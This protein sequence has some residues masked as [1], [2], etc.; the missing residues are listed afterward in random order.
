MNRVPGTPCDPSNA[1]W[2]HWRR[3]LCYIVS[4]SAIRVHFCPT[5]WTNE[6]LEI[7]GLFGLVSTRNAA[8]EMRIFAPSPAR[9]RKMLSE[10][11]EQLRLPVESLAMLLGTPLVTVR[12]WLNGERNP[13]GA[14]KRLIWLIHCAQF[15]PSV[16]RKM[17][18]W[19]KWAASHQAALERF[20]A[21]RKGPAELAAVVAASSKE[22]E[23][24]VPKAIRVRRAQ[25][26][27]KLGEHLGGDVRHIGTAL[28][29][30]GAMQVGQSLKECEQCFSQEGLDLETKLKLLD[31]K[32][33]LLGQQ[34]SL[35]KTMMDWRRGKFGPTDA[36]PRQP[37]FAPGERVFPAT[38]PVKAGVHAADRPVDTAV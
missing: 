33:A 24:H 28:I 5:I 19:T 21:D 31:L 9:C 22:R 8:K 27:A 36:M 13:S 23:F 10:I 38:L 15:K 17:D 30:F 37:T 12:K 35:A 32:T 14:A 4:M 29:V 1:A 7:S 2:F 20:T 3:L 16:L 6:Q 11:R 18:G 25:S 34:L 26:V